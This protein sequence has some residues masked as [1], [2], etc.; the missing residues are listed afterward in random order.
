[1]ANPKA[2][3][4]PPAKRKSKKIKEP[5][6]VGLTAL[7]C[8]A[9]DEPAEVE[10][11]RA[12]VVSDGGAVLG[13]YREPLAG[14]WTLLV[15]LP[16][17][18]VEPT[19]Y[20]RELSE[21]HANRLA[22]VIPKVGRFLDPVVLTRHASG[23]WTPNGMHR[24]VAMQRLGAR[25]IIGLLV[26]DADVALRIL[27]LNTEKAHNLKDKSLEVIRMAG[28]LAADPATGDKPESTWAFE[29]EEAAYLTIGL[30]YTERPRFSGGSYLSILKRTEEFAETPI[31]KSIEEKKKRSARVLELDDAVGEAVARLKEAGLKSPYLRAFVV[32]R[33]NPLRWQ[34]P[35]KPGQK[36]PR[37]EFEKTMDTM[38]AAA[39]KLDASKIRP[40]DVTA[41]GGAPDSSSDD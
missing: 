24:L 23:Y 20:Q 35:A 19:P 1:M 34:K 2:A 38:V 21:T 36:A 7:D 22:G 18:K 9:K 33:I 3:K 41:A 17:E 31:K 16:I 13:C 10:K 5:G 8:A 26:P 6:S 28:A 40:Q 14:E 27:A 32:A 29:F 37:G 11:L 12:Q 39:A 15:S 4:K 30:C 25:S